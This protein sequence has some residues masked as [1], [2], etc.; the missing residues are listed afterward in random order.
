MQ[1]IGFL[2]L[3]TKLT[4]YM[5]YIV[6]IIWK[7]KGKN[8]E[9]YIGSIHS[10]VRYF[11]LYHV[12]WRYCGPAEMHIPVK[13][14][15]S[16]CHTTFLFFFFAWLVT[17]LVIH[18]VRL[19]FLNLSIFMLNWAKRLNLFDDQCSYLIAYFRMGIE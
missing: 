18:A 3:A 11:S 17:I 8:I 2:Y 5:I 12:I 7:K 1:T 19:S 15:W 4:I 14:I 6:W 13:F 9:L 16:I 10:T